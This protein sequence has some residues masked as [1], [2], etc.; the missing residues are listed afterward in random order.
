MKN[1]GD[2][3]KGIISLGAITVVLYGPHSIQSDI[4]VKEQLSSGKRQVVKQEVY[5]I[6]NYYKTITSAGAVMLGLGSLIFYFS[7]RKDF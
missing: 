5:S 4:N 3:A 6:K 7:K 2:M 1:I